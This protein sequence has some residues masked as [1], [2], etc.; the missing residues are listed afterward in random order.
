MGDAT[1]RNDASTHG[2][3]SGAVGTAII[4]KSPEFATR[5]RA[6]FAAVEADGSVV[7][8]HVQRGVDGLVPPGT[9]TPLADVSPAAAESTDPNTIVRMGIAFNWVPN[10]TLYVTEGA[11]NRVAAF[12][13]TDDGVMFHAAPPRFLTAQGQLDV[14]VDV[15]PTQPEVASENFSSNSTAAGGADFYVLNRGDNSIVRVTQDDRMLAKRFLRIDGMSD[16][17]F[18]VAGL[19]T[20]PDGQTIWVTAT[21]ANRG[22]MVLKLPGFGSGDI[23][24]HLIADAHAAGATS[25]ADL[26]ARFFSHTLSV[27]EGLGPL[28]NAR[29]CTGCH[30]DPG[31]GGMGG[32]ATFIDPHGPVARQNAIPGCTAPTGVPADA[33]S[34]LRSAMTLRSTSLMDFVLRG[35]IEANQ[36]AEPAAVRGRLAILPDERLGRFGWK[37]DV[38]TLVEFLGGAFRNEMGVTNGLDRVDITTACDANEN[39]PEIDSVPLEANDVFLQG[40]DA[41]APSAACLGSAGATAFTNAGCAD[42]HAPSFP[43]PGFTV[44]LYTDL[45]LHDMGPG[46]ADNFPQGAATGSEF[47]TMQLT[48]VS[49][50]SRFLHDG[51][52]IHVSDAIEAHGG[53]AAAAKQAFDNLSAA[54]QQA[55]LSFL[56]CL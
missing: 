10:S 36:A 17:D 48:A 52:A 25:I 47:R 27:E 46:L 51:R 34:S 26:G 39:A 41:P 37:A 53:Q 50:R 11:Q 29:S 45:L 18:R 20:S 9:L 54:D 28:F 35:D 22:G 31:P 1:N 30:F 32:F 42:C 44:H 6:V 14:P 33:I 19:G 38:A 3:T 49:Q 8:V 5:N 21:T 16:C 24:S 4:H 56:G 2:L 15:Q 7:Q 23:M 40:I 12:D 13:V 43:G 55:L